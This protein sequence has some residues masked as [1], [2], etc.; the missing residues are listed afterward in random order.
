[1]MASRTRTYMCVLQYTTPHMCAYIHAY[2]HICIHTYIH[3]Y[4]HTR[5]TVFR[6]SCR[7]LARAPSILI[8]WIVSQVCGVAVSHDALVDVIHRVFTANDFV[9]VLAAR[10]AMHA[11]SNGLDQAHKEKIVVCMFWLCESEVIRTM[12]LCI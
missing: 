3:T 6:C 8:G 9:F 4:M 1:V 11:F 5:R 7:I 12:A 2:I 10:A